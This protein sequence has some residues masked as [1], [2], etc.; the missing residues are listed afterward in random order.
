MGQ[1]YQRAVILYN[2]ANFKLA[3]R[4]LETELTI[5]CAAEQY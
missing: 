5:L 4:E 2:Q 3:E 1:H